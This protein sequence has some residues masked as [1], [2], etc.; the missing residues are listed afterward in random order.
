M[1]AANAIKAQAQ[2][3]TQRAVASGFRTQAKV[4]MQRTAVRGVTETVEMAGIYI[5]IYIYI[6]KDRYKDT[7][8]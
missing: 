1:R 2:L 4:A 5:N 8:R 7:I 6:K 3:Q